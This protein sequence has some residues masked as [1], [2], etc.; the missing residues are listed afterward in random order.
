M[1]FQGLQVAEQ[2]HAAVDRNEI[3]SEK[4]K[5]TVSMEREGGTDQSW[6][7]EEHAHNIRRAWTGSPDD[8]VGLYAVSL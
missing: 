7:K 2:D 6:A 5:C 4:G 8:W 3:P 1:R